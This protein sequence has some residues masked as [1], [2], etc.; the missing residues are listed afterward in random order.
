[1]LDEF[2][3]FLDAHKVAPPWRI[4][5]SAPYVLGVRGRPRPKLWPD[6]RQISRLKR[7]FRE[8]CVAVPS[9]AG[10]TLSRLDVPGV[11]AGELLLFAN[12]VEHADVI[13]FTGDKNALRA[14][15]SDPSIAADAATMAGRVVHL[16]SVVEALLPTVGHAQVRAA[17]VG[18]PVDAAMSRAFALT[19]D[20][21]ATKALATSIATL[22][23]QTGNLLATDLSNL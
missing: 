22:R 15:A 14:L 5:P 2:D 23:G 13:V 7:F 18:H 17:I 16:E 8:R 6:P 1:M 11:D 19:D 21:A 20:A 3:A 10:S 4:V 12:A 9:A